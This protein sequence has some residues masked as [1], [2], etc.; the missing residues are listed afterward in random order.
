MKPP[1]RVTPAEAASLPGRL[2]G[3]TREDTVFSAAEKAIRTMRDAG[4]SARQIAKAERMLA[5]A[6]ERANI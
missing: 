5:A 2:S 3:V 4:F 1:R 6:K